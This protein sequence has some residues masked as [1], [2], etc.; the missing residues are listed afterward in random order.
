MAQKRYEF[1]DVLGMGTFGTVFQGFD[2]VKK[3][4]VAIKVI[5]NEPQCN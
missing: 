1:L 5:R 2:H 3:E 4:G